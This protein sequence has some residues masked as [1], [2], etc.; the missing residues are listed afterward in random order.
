MGGRGAGQEVLCSPP[1][2]NI[3][4]AECLPPVEQVSSL[5]PQP[6]LQQLTCD[7]VMKIRFVAL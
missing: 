1:P 4:D 5:P 2:N 7:V 3:V 6:T